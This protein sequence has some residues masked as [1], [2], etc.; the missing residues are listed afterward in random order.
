FNLNGTVDLGFPCGR[1]RRPCSHDSDC[2]RGRKCCNGPCGY[3]CTK[4]HARTIKLKSQILFYHPGVCPRPTFTGFPR[5]CPAVIFPTC[6]GDSQCKRHEKCCD[7]GCAR[8]CTSVIQDHPGVCPRPQY[9]KNPEF[10]ARARFAICGHD[11]QCKR[12]E[13]CCYNGCARVCTPVIQGTVEIK[14]QIPLAR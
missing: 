12:H 10:C 11:S 2:R 7:N 8:V 4:P 14:S 13:K 1:R 3:V 9:A 5:I 6:S